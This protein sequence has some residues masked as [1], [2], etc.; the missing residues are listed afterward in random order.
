MK[1]DDSKIRMG[2]APENISIL[3]NIVCNLFRSKGF[4]SIKYA[5]ELYANNVKELFELINSK[6]NLYKTT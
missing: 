3:R 2:M 5:I 6:T 1:E 4:Q